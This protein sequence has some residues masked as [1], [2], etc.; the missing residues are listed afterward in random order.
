M[1]GATEPWLCG[2]WERRYIRQG[3]PLSA[4]AIDD[5]VVVRYI[6]TPWG[7]VDVRV[8]AERPAWPLGGAALSSPT[9]AA[10]ALSAQGFGKPG[11][12]GMMAFA[13]V[14]V[15]READY[16]GIEVHWEEALNLWPP[17]AA[18]WDDIDAGLPLAPGGAQAL[19]LE[20][21]EYNPDGSGGVVMW[22]ERPHPGS[23]G[24]P[25]LEEWRRLDADGGGFF[26]ARCG[27]SL[28]VVAGDWFGYA[29]DGRDRAA[30]LR[31]LDAEEKYDSP[32]AVGRLAASL[33]GGFA[34]G[35]AVVY[36]AGRRSTGAP[37]CY[38]VY[39]ISALL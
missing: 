1:V 19:L 8:S 31:D 36:C 15:V 35:S 2:A 34:D 4:A 22:H 25:Y 10:A 13:G 38:T 37:R 26:C 12:A 23:A 39:S 21:E 32:G 28:L 14:T 33:C 5:S 20:R 9:A 6:Q 24:M 7:F 17:R 16:G 18:G 29:E 3:Q 11:W 27:D 30:L